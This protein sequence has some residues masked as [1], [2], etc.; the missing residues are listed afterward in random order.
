LGNLITKLQGALGPGGVLTDEDV[1]G[2]TGL[3]KSHIT[4]TDDVVVSMDPKWILNPG[5][6]FDLETG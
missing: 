4:G 3:L 5:K 1:T 2:R 6:I